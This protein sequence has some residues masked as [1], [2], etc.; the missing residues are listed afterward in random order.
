MAYYDHEIVPDKRDG[1]PPCL[2]CKKNWGSHKGWVC[3]DKSGNGSKSDSDP[4][5]RY[6]TADMLDQNHCIDV[7]SPQPTKKAPLK[8]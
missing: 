1:D 5:D 2:N 6:L 8:G 4:K 7:P 3:P